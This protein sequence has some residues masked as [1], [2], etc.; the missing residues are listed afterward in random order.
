VEQAED[1]TLQLHDRIPAIDSQQASPE[2]WHILTESSVPVAEFALALSRSTD[3]VSWLPSMSLFGILRKGTQSSVSEESS[4]LRKVHFPLQRGYSRFSSGPLF[5]SF[6]KIEGLL[7]LESRAPERSALVCTTSFWAPVAQLWPGPII[8]YATDFTFAYEGLR[9]GRVR[10]ADR[11]LCRIADLVCPNSANL[12]SYFLDQCYCPPDRIVVLPNATRAANIR[13]LPCSFPDPLP[14]D[15]PPLP[16]PIAGVIG[17]MAGNVDWTLLRNTIEHSPRYSWLFVGPTSMA[18][19][20]RRE[21]AARTTVM[22]SGRACFIGPKPYQD[23]FR[24]ARALDVAVMPYRKLEPTY[25]GSATRFYE[26]LAAGRPILATRSVEE[27]LHKQP[28]LHLVDGWAELVRELERL[29]KEP[30]DG[31]EETRRLA[32]QSETWEAR[33]QTMVEALH[34]MKRI[35]K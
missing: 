4:R 11:A 3:V 20:D 34:R 1:R 26:H 2:M 24:Y 12:A 6:S 21:R 30:Q 31:H 13:S 19:R 16:R 9:S 23:L 14:G 8:Y 28:L 15:V 33:A 17:N 29:R 32:S 10:S 5:Q 22:R 35:P 27:L 7:S 18:I 25:S